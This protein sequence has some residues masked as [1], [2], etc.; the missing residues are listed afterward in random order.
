M[1]RG[2]SFRTRRSRRLIKHGNNGFSVYGELEQDGALARLGVGLSTEGLK[3]RLDG[4]PAAGMAALA[5]RLAVHVIEPNMHR[6]I[7]GSP[8]ER[9]R[10]LDWGVFHVEQDYLD[11]WR[12]YRRILCQRNAA[13][14]MACGLEAWNGALVEAATVVDQARTRYLERLSDGLRGL[15]EKLLNCPLEIKYRRGWAGSA[16]FAEALAGSESRDRAAGVTQVGPHRADIS[17]SMDARGVREEV[18]RGQQKLVAAAL[19]LAQIRVFALGREDGGVLLVDDPAAELDRGALRGL[20][21]L[22]EGLPAQLIMT[23]LSET[24]LRPAP[25]YPVFHVEQGRVTPML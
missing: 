22:L 8:Q 14:K 5:Q 10:F 25:G 21:S 7:E 18:S 4:A 19:I 6:L 11:A 3:L 16:D 9:R 13:L 23:G 12:R 1:G 17:V 15:G 2:R 24:L 20:V